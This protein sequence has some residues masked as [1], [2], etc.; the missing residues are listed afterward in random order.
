MLHLQHAEYTE[1]VREY[2]TNR[3]IK[4]QL[5]EVEFV[6]CQYHEAMKCFQVAKDEPKVRVK[7]GY[8]LGRCFAAERWHK[9]AIEEYKEAL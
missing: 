3:F 1:R 6:R 2:P 8:M 7:A 4:Q 9:E 5:G